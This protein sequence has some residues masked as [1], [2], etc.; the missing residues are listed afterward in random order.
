MDLEGLAFKLGFAGFV[1]SA[2]SIVFGMPGADLLPHRL[3]ILM[4]FAGLIGVF[5]CFGLLLFLMVF[6]D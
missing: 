6:D 3:S 2:F 5:G 4:T 1:A